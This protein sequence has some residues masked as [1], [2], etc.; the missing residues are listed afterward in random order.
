MRRISGKLIW[1]VLM[2]CL[3]LSVAGLMQV[4][5]KEKSEATGT[6]LYL[7]GYQF[8][9]LSEVNLPEGLIKKTTPTTEYSNYIVRFTGPISDNWKGQL[10]KLGAVIQEYIPDFAYLVSMRGEKLVQVKALPYVS[11]IFAYEPAF[12]IH[13]E[14]VD[15]YG[16]KA[17]KDGKQDGEFIVE[18][19]TSDLSEIENT[20]TNAHGKIVDK[21][22]NQLKVKLNRRYLAE[23]AKIENVKY[24]EEAPNHK[25]LNDV[26]KQYV[27]VDDMWNLDYDG[28]GQIV[29]IC[30]TGLDT[31]KNDS[32][33]HLDFQGKILSMYA[34]GRSNDSSDP[35]GHGTHVAGSVLGSGARSNGQIKGMANGAKMVFQSVLDN[36]DGLG[37]IPADLNTLFAQA[38][39]DGARIHTNS[40]GAAVN[41]EYTV[42]SQAVDQFVNSHRDMIVLF[43]AGNN[44]FG[45]GTL[46]APGTAKN[47]ITVAASENY[48]PN[49]GPDADNPNCIVW[50]SSRGWTK[51]GR[52]KPDVAAP[53]TSILSTKSSLAPASYFEGVYND[54]YAYLSGTSMATPITAGSVAVARQ[55][56]MT[57][58]GHA[59]G[60]ALMKALLING[61]TNISY[62]YPGK[63]QGWGRVS[64]TNSLTARQINWVD[65]TVALTT[66]NKTTYTYNVLSN[67]QPLKITLTWSDAPGSLTAAKALVNDL[68]LIVTAPDGTVYYGNDFTAPFNDTFDRLNNVEQVTVTTPTPGSWKVEV[69]GYN[70]PTGPQSFALVSGGDMANSSQDTTPPT[71]RLTC[72]YNGATLGSIQMLGGAGNDNVALAYIA[73]YVDGNYVGRTDQFPHYYRWNT[74]EVADGLHTIY[75]KAFDTSGNS[76]VS[77]PVSVYIS[78]SGTISERFQGDV[79]NGGTRAQY[80]Y[81]QVSKP[82]T[83]NLNLGWSGTPDLDM[84]LYDPNGTEVAKAFTLANPE[85][86]TFEATTTG[87]Y[88]IKVDAYKEAAEYLLTAAHPFDSTVFN[89]L[90]STGNISSTGVKYKDFEI[91]VGTTNTCIN[92][93]AFWSNA[94]DMD[95]YLY[96]PNGNEVAKGYTLNNP[97][98]LSYYPVTVTGSYKVRVDAFEGGDSFTVKVNYAK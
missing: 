75:A 56:F 43:A 19:F 20:V 36:E 44:G 82:G 16:V 33:M 74:A 28:N 42:D 22:K 21:S 85:T 86:V 81:I 90:E 76:A 45:S 38:Y 39:N 84:Y 31:G 91:Y 94:A 10:V 83:V 11:E 72:P 49:I 26:A 32:S 67:T 46:S 25:V 41:G 3:L 61:A 23:L 59:P 48:R 60:A 13:P 12:K 89:H 35:H 62:A 77:A 98:C 30:D 92:V 68:D 37:G 2:V 40:W 4:A 18:L 29:A 71:A 63:D 14:L 50:F 80:W 7:K 51:D 87:V 78:N 64:L 52:I 96:D 58:Y 69:V 54:Y 88:K 47:C 6:M 65:E 15:E 57:N 24:I 1:T 9:S 5:A 8:K 97:E 93:E 73:Y 70:V 79:A 27:D 95:V 66:G 53:G 17:L 34:L 55:Y